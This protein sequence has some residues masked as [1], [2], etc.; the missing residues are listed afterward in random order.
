LLSS[1]LV[2]AVLFTQLSVA[3][4]ACPREASGTQQDKASVDVGQAMQAMPG[5]E[6]M[7]DMAETSQTRQ[8]RQ[9]PVNLN[10]CVE[11]CHFG[12]Q[13]VNHTEGPSVP[14]ATLTSFFVI[15]PVLPAFVST[16][17]NS[18][19]RH[20]SPAASPPHSILHCCFRI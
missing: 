8:T 12:H 1:I 7:E 16:G 20:L 18:V 15:A 14:P 9:A 17:R 2:G 3:A 6:H 5:C 10:L 19:A 4:Y 11:H 13:S